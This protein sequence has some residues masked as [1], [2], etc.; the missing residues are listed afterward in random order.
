MVDRADRDLLL[1][2]DAVLTGHK[3]VYVLD[4]LALHNLSEPKGLRVAEGVDHKLSLGG[5]VRHDSLDDERVTAWPV[6][7]QL[8]VSQVHLVEAHD[9]VGFGQITLARASRALVNYLDSHVVEQ[10]AIGRSIHL[11]VYQSCRRPSTCWLW[12]GEV[13]LSEELVL[14]SLKR[15]VLRGDLLLEEL[16]LLAEV[17]GP[18]DDAHFAYLACN[19]QSRSLRAVELRLQP[20]AVF[21]GHPTADAELYSAEVAAVRLVDMATC[22]S[23]IYLPDTSKVPRQH[24]SSFVRGVGSAG[25]ED[26]IMLWSWLDQFSRQRLPV[27]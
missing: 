15:Q 22:C 13:V 1:E 6:G 4:R 19:P 26:V 5:V 24:I 11:D 10:V 9:A 27:C 23:R 21:F 18:R 16:L 8:E 2:D 20:D 7:L 17:V 14:A 12:H 3:G 25:D